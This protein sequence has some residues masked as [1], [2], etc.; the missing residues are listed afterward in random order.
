MLYENNITL[1]ISIGVMLVYAVT[2]WARSVEF[3]FM[4]IG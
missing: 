4:A 2:I 1:L 3:V